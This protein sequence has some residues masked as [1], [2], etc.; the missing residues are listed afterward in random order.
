MRLHLLEMTAIGPFATRQVIDFDELGAGGLFLLD[1]PT[2]AGKT[3]VLDAITFALY[4]PGERGGDGRLHSDFASPAV[5]PEVRLDFSLRGVRQR[6]TRSPEYQRPK[7]RGGGHTREA[8][9]AHLE[10]RQAGGWV[11]RSSN[12]AEIADMLAED[13]GLTRD[14]FTQVVLLPQGDFARFL[15]ASDDDR[16]TL[17]TKLFGTQLYDRITSELERRGQSATKDLEAASTLTRSCVAAAAEAAGLSEDERETLCGLSPVELRRRLADVDGALK[18]EHDSAQAQAQSRTAACVRARDAAAHAAVQ[19]Q[20]MERLL[21]AQEALAEHELGRAAHDEARGSLAL[22]RRAEAVRG[23]IVS[24]DQSAGAIVGARAALLE[25]D[26][27]APRELLVGEGVNAVAARSAAS[28]RTAAE[29]QHV[30][31][32]E[33]GRSELRAALARARSEATAADRDVDELSARQ[34]ALPRE[35]EEIEQALEAAHRT[36]SVAQPAGERHASV[37]RQL[38]AA[39]RL[40]ELAPAVAAAGAAREDAIA[41]HQAAVDDHQRMVEARLAGMAAELAAALVEGAPCVV[42]GALAHPTPAL[43]HAGAVTAVDVEAQSR[44]R[45]STEHA[46]VQAELVI[47][48]LDSEVATLSVIANGGSVGE[49]TIEAKALSAVIADGAQANATRAASIQHRAA[50]LV[51]QQGVT[52]R[53]TSALARQSEAKYRLQSAH[54]QLAALN[55][56]VAAA[57]GGFDSV[58][59]RQTALVAQAQ[60][61]AALAEAARTVG[62]AARAYATALACATA[63]VLHAGFADIDG[64]RAAVLS[65][66]DI[67]S[68]QLF[69]DHWQQQWALL[70]GAV[71]A[72]EFAGLGSENLRNLRTA[73]D[74]AE[75]EL[76]ECEKHAVRAAEA[77]A[78]ARHGMD[79]FGDRLADIERAHARYDQLN[80]DAEPVL[81][82]S[83]ITR[84][85]AGQRRVALTTYV[86]RHWFEQVVRA[87][88]VRLVTISSGRY[89]LIRVDEGESKAER[90]GLTLQVIDRHT[91]E[92]RSPRSLSG[93]ETFYTSLALALGL[94]DV[95]R[96]EAGGI[97]LDT[98]FIDEGF[99]SLD[100]DTLDDVM[101][102]IEDLRDRGRVVGIVSHVTDL[103][104]LIHERIEVRRL[105]D[106]SS[107][108]RVVA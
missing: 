21:A 93:G 59:G 7:R 45:T 17:L 30:V 2:G 49:L 39:T 89:E 22:A 85:M 68:T 11:S 92:A 82:L 76:A 81:Y 27:T 90:T 69:V 66:V 25:L 14:Q 37:V 47:A 62:D 36:L 50:L 101:A 8:A 73:C 65:V 20:R 33:G 60:H 57:R 51:E 40:V 10:R 18:R 5:R 74:R 63:E 77:L 108:L 28:A 41:A 44:L 13:L 55:D 34:Q 107:A 61:D 38:A 88:N 32:R 80:A 70:H 97:D 46:R 67:E 84:G 98:L 105:A 58:V 75:E 53:Y 72:G 15:R 54:D 91:G 24:L 106:G 104:D 3:T 95:V 6:I 99:G 103:K 56:E 87:A 100:A 102:V 1:G 71:H 19:V 78:R 64:A 23:L 79:R 83:R 48:N 12:K 29:L 16:R 86:L 96:A 52:H 35:L 42:C 31:D 9:Q 94:A 4:G 43:R 26:P